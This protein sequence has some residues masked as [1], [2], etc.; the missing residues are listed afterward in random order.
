MLT[1]FIN[2]QLKPDNDFVREILND[3]LKVVGFLMEI[4]S[5]T[6]L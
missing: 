3:L 5:N 6:T 1:S 4:M 2:Y